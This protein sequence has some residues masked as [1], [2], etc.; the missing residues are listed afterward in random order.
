MIITTIITMAL[1]GFS[2]AQSTVSLF[3]PGTDN[4]GNLVAS[5]VSTI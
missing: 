3:L 1:I 5:V 4:N 2:S